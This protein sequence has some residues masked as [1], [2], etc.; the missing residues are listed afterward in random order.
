MVPMNSSAMSGEAINARFGASSCTAKACPHW[1]GGVISVMVTTPE[2]IYSPAPAPMR[3]IQ[4]E[5]PVKV[6]L[7]ANPRRPMPMPATESTMVALC[8]RRS[9]TNPAQSTER[10]YPPDKKTKRLALTARL[11]PRCSL[12]GSS[13]GPKKVRARKLAKNT[14]VSR[15]RAG[16]TGAKGSQEFFFGS[17]FIA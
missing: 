9:D 10:L 7:S 1:A 6:W 15:V 16:R 11:R 8:P 12:M 13:K 2:G 4:I 5:K 3:V 14:V 17:G